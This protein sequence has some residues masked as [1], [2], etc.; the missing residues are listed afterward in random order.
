MIKTWE[1]SFSRRMDKQTVVH[2]YNAMLFRAKKWK[3]TEE[4]ETHTGKAASCMI[5]T[6]GHSGKGTAMET[7]RDQWVS[8]V[9][10]EGGRAARLFCMT[11]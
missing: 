9:Q 4:M 7:V 6:L 2:P 1:M 11:M 3:D 8:G 10:E 5:P